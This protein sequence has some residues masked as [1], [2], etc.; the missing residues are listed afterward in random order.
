MKLDS[1]WGILP[2]EA[3]NMRDSLSDISDS[4]SAFF[5]DFS[6]HMQTVEFGIQDLQL[7][8]KGRAISLNISLS[9]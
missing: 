2:A 8:A 1:F 7:R 3:A 5:P 9:H 4:I 6:T